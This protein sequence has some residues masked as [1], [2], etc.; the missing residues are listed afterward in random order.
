MTVTV[1]LAVLLPSAVLTVM[2]AF[3][4]PLAVTVPLLTVATFEFEVVQ[5]TV[6][7]VALLGVTVAVKEDVLPVVSERLVLFRETPVTLTTGS[8][9]ITV[10]LAVLLPSAVLTVIVALPAPLAVTVPLL[11]VATLEFEVDQ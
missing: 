8:V 3:P 11:T 7:F 1:Q 4:A 5:L 6:L 10:Q 2:V 9:T